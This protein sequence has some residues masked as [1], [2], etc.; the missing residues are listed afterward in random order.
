[1]DQGEASPPAPAG[2][3]LPPQMRPGAPVVLGVLMADSS[4]WNHHYMTATWHGSRKRQFVLWCRWD[5]SFD[6]PWL[7][8]LGAGE[9]AACVPAGHP[10]SAS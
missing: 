5:V 9:L 1:M 10:S 2:K 3:D 6:C 4:F 8:Y 7:V